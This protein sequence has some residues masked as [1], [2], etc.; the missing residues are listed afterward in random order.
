MVEFNSSLTGYIIYSIYFPFFHVPFYPLFRVH[1]GR[2]VLQHPTKMYRRLLLDP[3]RH[4]HSVSVRTDR[5]CAA[6][7]EELGIEILD[8]LC[9]HYGWYVQFDIT[10]YK[11]S[12]WACIVIV[13]SGFWYNDHLAQT[14][15]R[16]LTDAVY[17][18]LRRVMGCGHEIDWSSTY[19]A[20]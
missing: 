8:A 5:R 15:L 2:F 10:I 9:G 11:W 19:Y 16:T 3:A 6:P 18:L 13:I 4:P 14:L 1:Y 20:P 12:S 7:D 17:H